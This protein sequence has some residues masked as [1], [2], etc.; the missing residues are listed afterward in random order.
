M[1]ASPDPLFTPSEKATH[2]RLCREAAIRN[3][4]TGDFPALLAFLGMPVRGRISHNLIF[5]IYAREIVTQSLDQAL[6]SFKPTTGSRAL[7]LGAQ[8][9]LGPFFAGFVVFTT[10]SIANQACQR[11]GLVAYDDDSNIDEK[12]LK[13]EC[14]EVGEM[15]INSVL[16]KILRNMVFT[17]MPAVLFDEI[18]PIAVDLGLSEVAG[19]VGGIVGLNVIGACVNAIFESDRWARI[20]M[21]IRRE[22]F[23]IH[24]QWIVAQGE[25]LWQD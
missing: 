4:K 25:A 21:V 23:K 5:L 8:I 10:M 7:Q 22:A 18:Y 14:K 17:A 12:N 3:K 13:E 9:F 6:E 11:L 24:M 15:G 20:A 1:P 19:L 2:A 16:R